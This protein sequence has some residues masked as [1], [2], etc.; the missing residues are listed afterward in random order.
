MNSLLNRRRPRLVCSV[1]EFVEGVGA[2][3]ELMVQ[4]EVPEAL[5]FAQGFC[6]DRVFVSQDKLDLGLCEFVY[7]RCLSRSAC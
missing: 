7:F 3:C 2:E 5:G 6:E 1:Q 4:F